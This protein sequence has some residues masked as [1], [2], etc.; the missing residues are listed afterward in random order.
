MVFSNWNPCVLHCQNKQRMSMEMITQ[1][2]LAVTLYAWFVWRVDDLYE[3]GT[4][5]FEVTKAFLKGEYEV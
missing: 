5:W 1:S 2:V 4:L 3:I